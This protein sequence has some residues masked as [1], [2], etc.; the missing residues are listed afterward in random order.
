ML[1]EQLKKFLVFMASV[2][3]LT[4][5]FK[6]DFQS[7]IL[8]IHQWSMI[9]SPKNRGTKSVFSICNVAGV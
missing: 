3:L 8:P 1:L 4:A 7:F 9:S 5:K 2:S 6:T